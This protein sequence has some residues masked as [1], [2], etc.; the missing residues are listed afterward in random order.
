LIP[1]IVLVGGLGTRLAGMSEGLPKPM[2]PVAGRPFVEFV[3][4]TLVQA[5]CPRI[6][7][8][9][10]HLRET[11]SRHFGCEYRGIPLEYS[12]EETPMG[13]GGAIRDALPLTRADAALVLN[14]DTLFRVDIAGLAQCHSRSAA[15]ITLALRR[16][17][18]T[19]RYGAVE[20]DE[21]GRIRAFHE[22]G[23]SGAGLVN[24]GVYVVN[25][26]VV[27]ARVTA[28]GPSSFERDVLEQGVGA[29]HL[30]GIPSD[31]YFIDIGVPE[32]LIRAR[33]ELGDG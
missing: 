25:A 21:E 18:D 7:L 32:D 26:E 30:L 17:T 23:R 28:A 33:S 14:G 12:V 15:D 20:A 16:V 27:R 19:A 6:V 11:I 4:D 13:T 5:G 8:A 22:K 9:V 10:S 29:L 3:L 24:G 1:A 31:G 2:V